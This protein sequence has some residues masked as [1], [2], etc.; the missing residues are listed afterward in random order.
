MTSH[1]FDPIRPDEVSLA[2]EILQASFPGV[3]LRF[4]VIDAQEPIKKDVVPYLEAERLGTPLPAKPA[5]IIQSLFHRLDT[6]AFLKAL[7]NLDTQAV[8]A[9]KELPKG[10]QVCFTTCYLY[11]FLQVQS[12]LNSSHRGL[13][14]SMR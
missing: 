1:P 5:R 9:V 10:V 8:V 13:A 3:S 2:A 11:V 14:I 4:K 6:K 12:I 7:I